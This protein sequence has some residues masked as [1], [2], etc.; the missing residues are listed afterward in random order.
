[1]VIP[2]HGVEEVSSCVSSPVRPRASGEE[3]AFL[4]AMVAEMPGNAIVKS[5]EI[6]RGQYV[7]LQEKR[8]VH[9]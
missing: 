7:D 5:T 8:W 9:T 6:L 3:E 1:M 2:A 4:A